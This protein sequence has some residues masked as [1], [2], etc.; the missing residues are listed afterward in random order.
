MAKLAPVQNQGLRICL[1][2]FRTTNAASL[3]V[4]ANE[5]PVAL[6][7]I[8]LSMQYVVKTLSNPTNPTQALL[9]TPHFEQR[10]DRTN[11]IRPLVIRIKHHLQAAAIDVTVLDEHRLSEVAP[12]RLKTPLVDFRWLNTPKNVPARTHSTRCTVS[13]ELNVITLSLSSQMAPK[14]ATNQLCVRV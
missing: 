1:N 8:K 12:W 9:A 5:M 6:R 10:F 3:H 14:L 13:L 2:A 11:A 4:E 7:H